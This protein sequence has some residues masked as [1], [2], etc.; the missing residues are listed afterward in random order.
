MAMSDSATP[1]NATL[2]GTKPSKQQLRR[3]IRAA[4]RALS[5]HRQRLASRKLCARLALCPEV[6]RARHIG[7]YWPMDGEI[8]PR[9]LLE[10]FP[11]KRFYLPALPRA[12]RT[13]MLFLHWPGTT[14]RY[15]NRYGIPEPVLGRSSAIRAD[16]LDLVLLP[17]VAFDP[18]GARLGMGAGYYDRTFA[19]K[20]LRPGSGPAL[21]GVAHQL[22]CVDHLPVEPWDIP[23]KLVATDQR[24]YRTL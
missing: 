16:R 10:R 20:Q 11:H 21:V 9:P 6:K 23:L 2:S 4:R 7:L 24:V 3:Q 14:P 17:L 12:A 5:A 8:D 22:Q 18:S 19:F 15:R 1:S 13:A